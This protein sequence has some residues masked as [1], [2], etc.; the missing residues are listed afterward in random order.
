VRGPLQTV[1][2]FPRSSDAPLTQIMDASGGPP[3][4]ADSYGSRSL[5]LKRIVRLEQRIG[6][7]GPSGFRGR[8]HLGGRLFVIVSLL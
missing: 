5:V 7:G 8:F 3:T 1:E 2:N 4:S 6:H